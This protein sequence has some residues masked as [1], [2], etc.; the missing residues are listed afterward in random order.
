VQKKGE[1]YHD[2]VLKSFYPFTHVI[3][4]AVRVFAF[5]QYG[6]WDACQQKSEHEFEK[7][8]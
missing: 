6:Q 3:K 8:V 5:E 4:P 1:K 7:C 2:V